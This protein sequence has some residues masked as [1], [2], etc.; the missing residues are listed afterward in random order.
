MALQSSTF[1]DSGNDYTVM[2]NDSRASNAVDGNT[3][4]EFNNKSCTH[5]D[6]NDKKPEWNL[7]LSGTHIVN[8]YVI[9]NRNG[10]LKKKV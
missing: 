7:T 3:S 5:T 6:N 8:R 4:P 1:V 10:N 2:Y 9:Y